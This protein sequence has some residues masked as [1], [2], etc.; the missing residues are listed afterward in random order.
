VRAHGCAGA[1]ATRRRAPA[2]CEDHSAAR[3]RFKADEDEA[4]NARLVLWK[5]CFVAPQDF[6]RRNKE[7]ATPLGRGC[8]A[9]A[10]DKLFPYDPRTP[11]GCPIKGTY[12]RRAWPY[13]G[14]CHVPRC[15]SYRR[16]T[17]PDR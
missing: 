17:N 6:R 5:G 15:G 11:P 2:H 1:D 14:I 10:F 16:T 4:R 9:G 13:R 3:G 8:P 12:A 7:T